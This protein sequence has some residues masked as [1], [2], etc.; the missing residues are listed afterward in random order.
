MRT[1]TLFVILAA[2]LFISSVSFSQTDS[3]KSLKVKN[4]NVVLGQYY[5]IF[6]PDLPPEKG[7]L[8]AVNK[9]SILMLI[10]N[11][12]EE[13]ELDDIAYVQDVEADNI[14]YTSSDSR[15]VK[16]VYSLSAGYLQNNSS[17]YDYSY[18]YINYNNLKFNGFNIS[19]DALLKISDNFGFRFDLTYL[20]TFGKSNPGY[21]YYSSYDTA[22]YGNSTDYAGLNL[23]AVKTGILFGSM[24]RS[25]PF[26]FYVYIGLGFGWTFHGN[27]IYYNTY[28][29]NG[30]TTTT[31]YQ[32]SNKDDLLLGAHA[33]IRLSYKVSKKYMLFVEPSIQYW[34]TNVN[35]IYAI[36]SG[37][38]FIL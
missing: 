19:G 12:V 24:S 17:Y 25:E 7:K 2:I 38:T 26:N 27:N 29:K 32:S 15:K 34:S 6:F 28:T 23:L 21:S 33:Q 20:H 10:K 11:E 8:I 35:R 13:F 30:V 14:I 36:N 22:T 9:S 1:K 18:N 5:E 3:I 4:H 31:Q 37:I 16:P